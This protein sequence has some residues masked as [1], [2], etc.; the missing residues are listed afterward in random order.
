MR[1]NLLAIGALAAALALPLSVCAQETQPPPQAHAGRTTTPSGDKL[2]RHWAKRF[3]DLNL[4]ADQQHQVQSII[5][6]YSQA[7]P[8]GS[9]RDRNASRELR[10]ELMGVLTNDQKSQF[11]Q[12]MRARRDQMRERQGQ[13]QQGG[14]EQGYQQGQPQQYQQGP[15]QQYQQGPPQQYQQGPP[16]Q[17]QQGPPQQYQQGPPDQQ[18]PQ[19]P[20]DQQGPPPA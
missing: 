7:H 12:Q 8:G 17:Y 4:S 9:P 5:D 6:Q 13:M 19:G 20:P 16:Q 10:H 1:I 14:D 3:G 18:Y 11:K 15:P 2:Q